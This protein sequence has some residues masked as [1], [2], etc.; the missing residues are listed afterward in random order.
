MPSYRGMDGS[1]S[2]PDSTRTD[3]PTYG[4]LV[5][6]AC[7]DTN[8]SP[9]GVD[10]ARDGPEGH[11][12]QLDHAFLGGKASGDEDRSTFILEKTRPKAE[13]STK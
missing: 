1:R 12:P 5:L 3:G 8:S 11:G 10:P 9:E 4:M 7:D 6:A 2:G 13:F